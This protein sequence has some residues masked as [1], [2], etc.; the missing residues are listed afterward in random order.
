VKYRTGL[1]LA[2]VFLV[3]VGAVGVALS[4][5]PDLEATPVAPPSEG[6]CGD[7]FIDTDAGEQCDPGLPDASIPGCSHCNIVCGDDGGLPVYLDPTSNHCYFLLSEDSGPNELT[8]GCSSLG[9]H[10]VTLGS[11]PELSRL[12]GNLSPTPRANEFWL[13]LRRDFDAGSGVIYKSVVDEP[14]LARRAVCLGCFGPPPPRGGGVVLPVNSSGDG[15]A[16]PLCVTWRFVAN[17]SW[18]ATSCE[19]NYPTICER[20][21]VGSRGYSCFDKLT[22]FTVQADLSTSSSGKRYVWSPIPV[23]AQAASTVCAQFGDAGQNASLVIF[24]TDEEREQVFHEL[25]QHSP[26]VTDFWIG[27]SLLPEDGPPA[28]TW[29]N[30]NSSYPLPWGDHEPVVASPGARAFARQT[31]TSYSAPGATYDT[32]LSH[33]P[34]GGDDAETHSVLCQITP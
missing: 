28:W 32:Q 6:S 20:E 34:D 17:A 15:G 19:A 21:P 24:D 30:G 1:R 16:D 23:T 27:L 33:V 12:A 7:G 29:D 4:C 26:L 25:I 18:Y 2:R 31:G 11:G 9:A 8:S 5:L 13:G 3:F 14:G 10:V 22:C